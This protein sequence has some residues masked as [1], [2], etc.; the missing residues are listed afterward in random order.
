MSHQHRAIRSLAVFRRGGS[1]R[2]LSAL[3]GMLGVLLQLCVPLVHHPADAASA[4]AWLKGAICRVA[5]ESTPADDGS[6]PIPR[7][8]GFCPIC[9][10]LSLGG[11]LVLPNLAAL[12]LRERAE[13]APVRRTPAIPR[14]AHWLSLAALPRAPPVMA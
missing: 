7:K 10:A 3:L 12:A 8:P 11:S 5:G 4:P 1:L 2:R 9:L 14:P 6:A 13:S